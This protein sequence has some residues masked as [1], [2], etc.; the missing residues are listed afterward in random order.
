MDTK[1]EDKMIRQ[2]EKNLT[3]QINEEYPLYSN[4]YINKEP[5]TMSRAEYIRQARESCLRQLSNTQ[6]YSKPY[7][8]NYMNMENMKQETPLPKKSKNW[9]LFHV[10][11]QDNLVKSEKSAIEENTPQEIA[12]F[13]SLVIRT[14]CAIVIFITIFVINKFD[15]NIGAITADSIREYVTGNDKLQEL[16]NLVVTW[17]K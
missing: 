13:H 3:D 6:V 8:V 17:L 2:I 1:S 15:I 7:D 14:V 10:G 12:S 11:S 5:V 4:D 16:E 9:N